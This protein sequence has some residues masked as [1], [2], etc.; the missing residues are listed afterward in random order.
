MR[1]PVQAG[2]LHRHMFYR[3]DGIVEITDT[4]DAEA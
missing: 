2:G 4:R 3:M 1:L